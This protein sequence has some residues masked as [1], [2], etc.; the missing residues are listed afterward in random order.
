MGVAPPY[1]SLVIPVYNEV[2]SLPPLAREIRAALDPTGW[3][4]EV[5]FVDDGSR[6]GSFEQLVALH[7]EDGRFKAIRLRR[8]YGQTAAFAAGFARARGAVVAT[9]DADGQNPPSDIPGLVARLNEGYDVVNGWRQR[10]QDG[11]LLR[12]LPSQLANRLI[13]RATGVRLHDRGCSLRVFRSEAARALRL[14]GEMHRFIPELVH[15]AG[16]AM[17]EAPVGHRPRTAGRSKYGLARTFRVL[18]DLLTVLFLG[19]YAD[20][21]MHLFG[22]LG[23]LSGGLGA[24]IG[25]YLS[26]LK[27]WAGIQGGWA[28]FQ[29][30]QIGGRPLLLLAVL[31]IILGGQF[32][33]LGL[34]AE[35]L[36]R[37]YYESRGQPVYQV[38]AVLG[39]ETAEEDAP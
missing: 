5:L 13:A 3:S 38:S 17:T 19:N 37:T 26:W 23:I 9:L 34:L 22:S 11:W 36:V 14:Y 20:R 25:L 21:P 27:I 32:F 30:E 16:F 31:L 2:D 12:R 7:A 28:G 24:A 8:N 18:L 4:Y 1:L 35:L 6:D 15:Q 39:E 33:M 10:R 29:A